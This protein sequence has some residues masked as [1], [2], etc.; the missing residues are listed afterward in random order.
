MEFDW[1]EATVMF[2]LFAVQLVLPVFFGHAIRDWITYAFL[3]WAAIAVLV[4]IIRRERPAALIRF[5]ETWRA[6]V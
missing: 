6:N 4:M 5:A 3:A 2:V 1:W